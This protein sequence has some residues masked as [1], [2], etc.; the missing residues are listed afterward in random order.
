MLDYKK[1]LKQ[2]IKCGACMSVCPVYQTTRL[3]SD[4]ARG[5]LAVLREVESG[6]LDLSSGVSEILSRCLSCGAC[7]EVCANSVQSN[8]LIQ[9]GRQQDFLKH[10]PAMSQSLL[11]ALTPEDLSH[12]VLIKES[13]LLEKLLCK[14]VPESSG[15]HL[16]FP[17][18]FFTQRSIIPQISTSPF[19]EGCLP[20]EKSAGGKIRVGFFVGCGTNYLFPETGRALLDILKEVSIVPFI[21]EQ[22][23]C[24]G[25]MAYSLGDQKRAVD[26]AKRTIDL[27]SDQRLDYI[28]TTCASC[29]AQLKA[30]PTLFETETERRQAEKFSE[31]VMDVTSFLVDVVGYDKLGPTRQQISK[32]SPV[33]VVY[34]DPCHLRIKQKVVEAPMRFLSVIPGIELVE[35]STQCCGHGGTF[36]FF[37]YSLSMQ[38]L[39]RRMSE[40]EQAQPDK[41]VTGC[42]G[43][44]L[45]LQEG[46][47]RIKT[48]KKIDVLHPLVLWKQQYL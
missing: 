16:R 23:G 25:L 38:I 14:K 34:H 17:L 1:A 40:I 42:T 18:S 21:P 26:L 11:K 37:N 45:Q 15:L 3:E 32:G 35:L 29:G 43:C 27:F 22:Q 48:T 46:I 7:A 19:L 9:Y 33:R 47:Q 36:N 12:N 8:T 13:A 41:I 31:K 39:D 30:F 10:K 4:V 28:I 20:D 2:C 24:C 44:L 5:K 6:R